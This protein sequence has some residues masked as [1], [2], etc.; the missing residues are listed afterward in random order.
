MA[1]KLLPPKSQR[2]HCSTSSPTT[3]T[4]PTPK[5]R[6]LARRRRPSQVA[7]ARVAKSN[8]SKPSLCFWSSM[9]SGSFGLIL[10]V[11]KAKGGGGTERLGI[12]IPLE[13]ILQVQNLSQDDRFWVFFIMFKTI[14]TTPIHC[15]RL[16]ALPIQAVEMAIQCTLLSGHSAVPG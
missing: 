15:R 6:L 10:Y 16:L 11:Q 13:C 4:K 9:H 1:K 3:E 5:A 12:L 7:R 8:L 14:T 2:T